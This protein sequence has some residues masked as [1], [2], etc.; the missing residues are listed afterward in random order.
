M[1]AIFLAVAVAVA[2][3]VEVF[4][5]YRKNRCKF[6]G[7]KCLVPI[8]SPTGLRIMERNGWFPVSK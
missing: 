2:V 3:A 7:Q 8:S 4:T 1:F 5:Q 6:C